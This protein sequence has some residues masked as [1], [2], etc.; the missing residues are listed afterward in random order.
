MNAPGNQT[1]HDPDDWF[2]EP[3]PTPPRQAGRLPAQVDPDTQTHEMAASPIDDWLAPEPFTRKL[4][5]PRAAP[6]ANRRILIALAIALALLLVGL[7]LGGVFSGSGKRRAN[8]PPTRQ[9]VPTTAQSA[10]PVPTVPASTL[11]LGD[12]GNP[13]K[14]LQRALKSIGFT[15]GTIDGVFGPST[16]HALI[17]FQTAHKLSPDGVLGPATRAA[18]LKAV[19][20]G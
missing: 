20:A 5:S 12:R 15:V 11:K 2:D 8:T 10:T 13:V 9:T 18:L 14:E 6:I 3:E 17:R 7:A 19:R 1:P 16:E 4:R